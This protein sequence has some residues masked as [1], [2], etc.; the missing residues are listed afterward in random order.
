MG[1][2]VWLKEVP[3][4]ATYFVWREKLGRILVA[5]SLSKHDLSSTICCQYGEVEETTD[6]ILVEFQFAKTVWEWIF[7]WCSVPSADVEMVHDV[8]GYSSSWET[9]YVM[10]QCGV[11]GK[12]LIHGSNIGGINVVYV[13]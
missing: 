11:L 12:R 3:I 7:R 9:E 10:V 1:D 5:D 6:H 2:F 13:V 4:N 8:L